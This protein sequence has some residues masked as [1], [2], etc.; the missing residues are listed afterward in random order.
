MFTSPNCVCLH[1]VNTDFRVHADLR[2]TNLDDG[3]VYVELQQM[4]GLE[5]LQAIGFDRSYMTGP[6]PNHEVCSSMAG[7]AFSAFALGPLVMGA[8]R[9]ALATGPGRALSESGSL[10]TYGSSD[11]ESG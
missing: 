10:P 4:D 7:N 8:L 9:A 11:E 1:T 6:R 5:M 2:C 3:S